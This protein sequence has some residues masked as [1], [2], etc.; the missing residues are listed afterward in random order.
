MKKYIILIAI[1]FACFAAKAQGG[2]NYNSFGFGI[3]GGMVHPLADLKK[4][5]ND[6]AFNANLTYYFNPYVPV[7][8]EFQ[9]GKLRGGGNDV[10][11][12]KDTRRFENKYKALMLHVDYQLGDAIDYYRSGFLNIIKNFYG[13]I[14]VGAIFNQVDANRYSLIQINPPYKFPGNDK[15]V[16]VIVPVRFGYEFKIYDYYGV[17]KFG[18]DIGYQHYV[19]FGEGLDGYGDPTATFKNNSP[20][21]FRQISI[22]LKYNFGI[23]HSYDKSIKGY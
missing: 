5:F 9:M 2:Y 4:G 16:N 14:G 20:D 18:I 3:G 7:V 21:Q 10:T 15:S 6:K 19:T 23:E 22:G 1:T 11:L 17:P 13:G 8:L 12:D